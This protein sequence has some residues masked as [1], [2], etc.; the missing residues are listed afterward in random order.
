[1]KSK[2]LKINEEAE[3]KWTHRYRELFDSCQ[4]GQG[5]VEC[6]KKVKELRSTDWL[7]QNSFMDVNYSIGNIVN[8]I[9]VSMNGVRWV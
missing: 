8:N 3:H 9:L 6:V 2:K 5:L 7:L 4:M 1:M